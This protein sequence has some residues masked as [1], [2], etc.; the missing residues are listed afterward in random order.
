MIKLFSSSS[1]K[2]LL[3][4]FIILDISFILSED[5]KF[6]FILS[7]ILLSLSKISGL[8]LSKNINLALSQFSCCNL[9][10]SLLPELLL[11]CIPSLI[12]KDIPFLFE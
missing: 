8:F 1:C 3:E 2:L 11:T 5:N 9:K 7:L 6:I 10:L 12:S 4:F